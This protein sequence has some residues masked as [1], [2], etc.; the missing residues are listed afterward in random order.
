MKINNVAHGNGKAVSAICSLG[1]DGIRTI[2]TVEETMNGDA[3]IQCLIEDIFPTMNPCPMS[4]SVLVLDN[5][6]VHRHD[7]IFYLCNQRGILVYFLPP[8]SYDYN[9]IELAFHQAKHHVRAKYGI[10]EGHTAEKIAE[11]LNT[12]VMDDAINYFRHCGYPV[13]PMDIATVMV[14]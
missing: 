12:V 8:Y 14:G 2:R 3:F 9:P 4:R 13:T 5:A 11:G 10:V 1:L 7:E 6:S